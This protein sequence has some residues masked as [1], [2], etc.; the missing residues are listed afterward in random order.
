MSENE[1]F[2][3][4]TTEQQLGFLADDLLKMLA[5][6]VFNCQTPLRTKLCAFIRP[7]MANTSKPPN[8]GGE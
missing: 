2:K 6:H 1:K 8:A 7:Y 3:E 4:L 5:D